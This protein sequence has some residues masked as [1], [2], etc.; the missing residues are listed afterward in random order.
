MNTAPSTTPVGNPSQSHSVLLSQPALA[1][2][3]VHL[4]TLNLPILFP[5]RLNLPQ[6]SPSHGGTQISK[7][8]CHT[9]GAY[10]LTLSTCTHATFPFLLPPI[11]S[12]PRSAH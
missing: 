4:H 1:I 10:V 12:P 8:T 2:H 9:P 11:I 5:P 6:N 3:H 7:T